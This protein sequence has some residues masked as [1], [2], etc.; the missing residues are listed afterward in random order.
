MM[1]KKK[2]T[3]QDIAGTETWGTWNR[4][5]SEFPWY[6]SEKETCYIL[7][8]SARVTAENG[9]A[10]EFGKGDMVTF[11]AGLKCTWRIDN[12]IRKRFKFG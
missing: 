11:E 12:T 5:P 9:E 7:E 10:I 8:G 1:H 6:Y 2:P 4:E 3:E